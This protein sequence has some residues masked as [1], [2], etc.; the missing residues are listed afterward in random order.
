MF[1][2]SVELSKKGRRDE[3]AARCRTGPPRRAVQGSLRQRGW[4]RPIPP[5]AA[6]RWPSCKKGPPAAAKDSNTAKFLG[7]LSAPTAQGGGSHESHRPAHGA[8][9]AE[10]STVIRR[11]YASLHGFRYDFFIFRTVS[12]RFRRW[13][14]EFCQPRY[15][16]QWPIARMTPLLKTRSYA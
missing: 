9:S 13:S 2:A 16:D 3:K 6:R 12:E 7:L 1:L 5:T 10:M 15:T 14:G 8:E 4:L 11:F